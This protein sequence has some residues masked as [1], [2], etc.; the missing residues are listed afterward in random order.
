MSQRRRLSVYVVEDSRT[1]S[2]IARALLEKE[3]HVVRVSHA[4]EEALREIPE[5]RP[6]CVLVD[7]MLP[8]LDGYELVRRLRAVPA[9]A[10]TKLVMMSTKAYDSDRQRAVDLGAHGYFVKPLHPAG[11]VPELERIVSDTLVMTFWGVRGT[12]PV[13]RRDSVRYGGNTSCV[14]LAFPDGRLLIFDAGTG[15]KALGDALAA[16]AARIDAR[17]LISHPHWDHI[18]AL[19]FFAPFYA[20]GNRFEICGPAHGATTMRDLIAVQMDGVYFPVTTREFAA[21]VSYRDLGAGHHQ[22]GDLALQAMLLRHPGTCLGYRLRHG[23]RSICYVTDNELY[24]PDHELYSEDYLERLVEFVRGADVLITDATYTDEEYAR[25]AGWGH[26]SVSQVADLAW[27][28]R[29]RTLY[30][31][32]HDPDQSDTVI[33]DKLE[34][35]RELLWARGA[36]TEVVAPLEYAE[37]E[38]SGAEEPP[39]T[40][41]PPASR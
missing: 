31:I 39:P 28:S 36:A 1:Q 12:L 38:L 26:S 35:A 4:S 9:L 15:I 21:S 16:R 3:G 40:A 27:R 17:I 30:L 5:R 33:D 34:Q 18:N 11:F 14:G 32:H 37:V 29:V 8:G 24:P 20:R 23:G 22:L 7:I 41:P 19:P 2:D 6:D 25:R 13:S 10:H